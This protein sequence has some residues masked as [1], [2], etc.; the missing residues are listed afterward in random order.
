MNINRL[1]G[2]FLVV[3]LTMYLH[4][5]AAKQREAESPLT[6]VVMDRASL[7]N[8]VQY[9]SIAAVIHEL[10]QDVGSE[11]VVLT[12]SSL[13][14]QQLEQFSFRMADSLGVGRS[15]HNDGILITV[16]FADRKARIEAGIGLENI[17]RDEVAAQIM[18]EQLAPYFRKEN[19]GRGIY[20]TVERIAQL[21]RKNKELVGST[22]M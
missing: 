14:G 1:L 20:L 6:D 17:I 7:L 19:Y 22:P 8:A 9:D 3:V 21:I 11:I 16:A 18:R 12:V 15:T 2:S 10:K 13:N 5:C 4:S